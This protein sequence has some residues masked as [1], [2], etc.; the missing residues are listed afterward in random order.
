[1]NGS[2]GPDNGEWGGVVPGSVVPEQQEVN[3]EGERASD[4]EQVASAEF[5][6]LE[7]HQPQSEDGEHGR[8]DGSR[9][10]PFTQHGRGSGPG[11]SR[12]T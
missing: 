9:P 4:H 2:G 10:G 7:R 1:M 11:G 12:R 6:P 3:R 5:D 8:D